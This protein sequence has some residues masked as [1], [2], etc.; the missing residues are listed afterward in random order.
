MYVKS[1]KKANAAQW[2]LPHVPI[3]SD[4]IKINTFIVQ[5]LLLRLSSLYCLDFS[6]KI[7]GRLIILHQAT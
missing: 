7:N 4:S 1:K 6:L 2:K 3:P 5:F